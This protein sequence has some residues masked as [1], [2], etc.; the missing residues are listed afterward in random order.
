MAEIPIEKKSGIPGWV[1][2]LLALLIGALLLWWLLDDDGNDAV[3]YTGSDAVAVAPADTVDPALPAA[4]GAAAAGA[5]AYTVGQTVDLDNVRVTSLAGDQAFNAD[6]N[7]QPMFVVFNEV[8]S[9]ADPT[10]EGQIDVNP[11]S[12]VNLEGTIRAAS[13]PLPA[14]STAQIPAGTQQY[15]YATSIEMVQ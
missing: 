1:W 15:L 7:G 10:V 12:V 4:A 2:L 8:P 13:E 6:V 14:G 11:G 3:E 5:A 9:P